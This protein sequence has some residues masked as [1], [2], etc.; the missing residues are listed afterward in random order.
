VQVDILIL[1]AIKRMAPG[2]N[3]NVVY[4]LD[5]TKPARRGVRLNPEI[6]DALEPARGRDIAILLSTEFEGLYR[7]GGIGTYYRELNRVLRGAGWYTILFDLNYEPV[8]GAGS[9][10]LGLDH[11]LCADDFDRILDLDHVHACML[12]AARHSHLEMRGL[13][14]MLL[15]QALSNAF[16]GQRLYAE[17]HEMCGFGYHSAKAKE[18]GW[19]DPEVVVAVTMHSGH[20]WLHEANRALISQ[21]N[22]YFINAAAMEEQSF[23]SADL[24]MF[25][26]ESLH[27]IVQSYG[28]RT[29]RAIKIP[30]FIPV[31]DHA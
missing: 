1:P 21:S 31:Q 28:W 20:E 4:V 27:A 9:A 11:L 3:I 26:S 24:A 15:I 23:R 2:S 6:A 16:P 14:C 17:F 18:S 22:E 29:E 10:A 5:P 7:N 12:A 30:Y 25:P 13:Q 19:L 8:T